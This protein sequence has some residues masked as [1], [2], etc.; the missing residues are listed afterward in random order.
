MLTKRI[1]CCENPNV[2]LFSPSLI[3]V[4]NITIL[5]VFHLANLEY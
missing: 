4:L 3:N 1:I 5:A 2:V